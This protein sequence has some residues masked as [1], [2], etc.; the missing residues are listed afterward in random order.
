M[1]I[2]YPLEDYNP[3]SQ[4]KWNVVVNG[5]RRQECGK[6]RKK[7]RDQDVFITNLQYQMIG[8]KS[9]SRNCKLL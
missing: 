9:S 3:G 6:V 7:E 2:L 1:P 5:Q 8:A 4:E